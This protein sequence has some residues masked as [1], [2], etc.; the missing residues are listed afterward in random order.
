MFVYLSCT[1][2]FCKPIRYTFYEYETSWGPAFAFKCAFL[3]EKS[4]RRVGFFSLFFPCMEGPEHRS[5]KLYVCVSDRGK[6]LFFIIGRVRLLA[7]SE[8]TAA[9]SEVS[10]VICQADSPIHQR[11]QTYGHP[12]LVSAFTSLTRSISCPRMV[13]RSCSVWPSGATRNVV[14]PAL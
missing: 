13:R 7:N 11:Y 14:T 2:P 1:V 4:Y 3:H 9:R 10:H 12:S 5:P 8:R 6:G